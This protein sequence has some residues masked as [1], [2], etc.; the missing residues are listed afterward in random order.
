[1]G[2]RVGALV[3]GVV[4]L[5]A[6]R[7]SGQSQLPLCYAGFEISAACISERGLDRKKE[8]YQRTIADAMSRLGA[9]YKIALR[10]VNDPVAAGYDATVSDVFT[11]W[12]ATRRCATSRSSSRAP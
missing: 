3:G 10:I 4:L 9:S 7:A 8:Q 6:A 5:I 12:C 1:M 2:K 11:G